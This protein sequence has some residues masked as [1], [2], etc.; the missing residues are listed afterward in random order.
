MSQ[1]PTDAQLAFS[2]VAF[3]ADTVPSEQVDAAFGM[4]KG[5][6]R[7]RA[8]IFSL[9][10]AEAGETEATL[11]AKAALSALRSAGVAAEQA[12]WILATSETHHA[13]PSLAA[14]LH[15]AIGARETCGALDLGG[16]CLGFLHTLAVAQSLVVA[17]Q[18]RTVLVVTADVHSRTL[19]P[20]RVAGEFGGL[21]GDG[22]S[23]VLVQCDL[24][25]ATAG[26]YALRE[27]FFG[28]A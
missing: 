12:D 15:L 22:A 28:C 3:G 16:A 8:G 26:G 23:A 6:L 20:G 9:S 19:T 4:P 25:K 1:R 5:K 7:E 14:Q 18:A 17:G 2:A 27:F 11:G 24:A 13:V 21:F 10:Y